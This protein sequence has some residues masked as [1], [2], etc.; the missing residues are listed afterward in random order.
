MKIIIAPDKFKGTL[1]APEAAGAIRRGWAGA[2]PLD[3]LELWPMSDGGDG[4]GEIISAL[5]GA[6]VQSVKTVDAAH[7]PLE[8]QWWWDAGSRTAA[9]CA[10]CVLCG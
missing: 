4:F 1:T 7:R 5:L 3:E 9:L 8:A 6:S 10:L 2:R